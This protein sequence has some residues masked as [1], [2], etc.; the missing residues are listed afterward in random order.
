MM[1]LA[2]CCKVVPDL[3]GVLT[4]D[5]RITGAE[6]ETRFYKQIWSCFDESALEMAISF[7][8]MVSD[9]SISAITIDEDHA[10]PF[11]RTLYA[12]RFDHAIRIQPSG[13]GD[14]FPNHIAA[15][16]AKHIAGSYDMVLLGR[17][18]GLGN[19]AMT[20]MLLAELLRWP[21][22]SQVL[23]VMPVSDGLVEVK[24]STDR[25]FLTQVVRLPIVLTVGNVQ[26]AYLRVPTLKDRVAFGKKPI[27]VVEVEIDTEKV[28]PDAKLISLTRLNNTRS[29]TPIEGAD[30]REKAKSFFMTYLKDRV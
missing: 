10:D 17:Q 8:E 11:L 4:S 13:K 27:E 9:C 3:D 21:C 28:M 29:A 26:N 18:S 2:V 24:S 12:L 6:V 22:I 20:P 23:S 14:F 5:I 7:R 1:R 15:M 30:A 19:N 16:L 25:G